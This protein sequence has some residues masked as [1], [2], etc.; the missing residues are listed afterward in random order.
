LGIYRIFWKRFRIFIREV[1][2]DDIGGISFWVKNVSNT[3]DRKTV[4]KTPGKYSVS[5]WEGDCKAKTIITKIMVMY[6][7]NVKLEILLQ[8]LFRKLR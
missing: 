1:S 8:D 7:K 4:M 2:V 5:K 6:N 3:L